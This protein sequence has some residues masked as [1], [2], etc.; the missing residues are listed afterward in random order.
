MAKKNRGR[1][2]GSISPRSNGRWRAQVS[3]C[4]KRLSRDFTTKVQCQRWIREVLDKKDQGFNFDGAQISLREFLEDWLITKEASLRPETHYQY[5]M[6]CRKYIIPLLGKLKLIELRPEHIQKLYQAEK[7]AGVGDRTIEM[8]HMVLHGALGHAVKLGLL[9][10]N[11]TDATIP[12]RPKHKEMKFYDETQVNQ[13]LLSAK[14]DNYEMIYYLAIA[15]GMRQS[16]LLGLKWSDLDWRYKTIIVQRQLT[17]GKKDGDYFTSL[18]TQAGYRTILLGNITIDKLREHY[19][20][21]QNEQKEMGERW[22]ENDLIFP[23]SIG[24]PLDQYN[25]YHK[26]KTLIQISGLP[27]IRF[28]DLRHT[29]ASLMLNHGIPP[30]IVSRRL[31]HSKVSITLDIYGHLIQEMQNEAAELIDELI[32]PI[33]VDL[34]APQLHLNCTNTLK[35]TLSSY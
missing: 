27:E 8:I 26:F 13:F 4:G 35:P 2:E 18:K 22:E 15:T 14:G 11:P 21:Q 23:S 1:N 19:K 12:I 29:A 24:T 17:R 28:H 9:S 16:E 5:S 32:S 34:I 7:Q 10:R 20:I 3:L 33:E 6:T 25:L 30:I 31:G